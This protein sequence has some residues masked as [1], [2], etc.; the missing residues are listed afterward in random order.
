[1]RLSNKGFG[2]RVDKMRLFHCAK[3]GTLKIQSAKGRQ[4]QNKFASNDPIHQ[5]E[6]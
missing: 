6:A 5:L 2:I 4:I 1:M 3:A